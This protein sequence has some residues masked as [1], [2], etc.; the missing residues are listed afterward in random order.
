M[1]ASPKERLKPKWDWLSVIM[2]LSL[3]S[4]DILKQMNGVAW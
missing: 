4:L 2:W 3:T 1:A